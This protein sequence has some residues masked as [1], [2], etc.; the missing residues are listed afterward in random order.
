MLV[1]QSQPKI[2]SESNLH[3]SQGLPITIPHYQPTQLRHSAVNLFSPAVMTSTHYNGANLSGHHNS[4]FPPLP[5]SQDGLS[6]LSKTNLEQ[7]NCLNATEEK[8]LEQSLNE[9]PLDLS[10]KNKSD[11]PHGNCTNVFK[12]SLVLP[13]KAEVLNLSQKSSRNSSRNSSDEQSGNKHKH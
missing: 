7:T 6:P 5:F 13:A 11:S 10:T 2:S 12:N 9:Q 3:S 8:D 1:V 4:P